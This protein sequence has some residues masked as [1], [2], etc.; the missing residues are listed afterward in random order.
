M[1]LILL[2]RVQ[3]NHIFSLLVRGQDVRPRGQTDLL[4]LGRKCGR[5]GRQG[6]NLPGSRIKTSVRNKK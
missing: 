2:G 6:V 4:I 5:A 1:V 3:I